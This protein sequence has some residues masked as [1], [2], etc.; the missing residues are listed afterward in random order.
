MSDLVCR[1]KK[2]SLVEDA[3][4]KFLTHPIPSLLSGDSHYVIE[5]GPFGAQQKA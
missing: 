3:Q 4:R 2:I 5:G 1:E